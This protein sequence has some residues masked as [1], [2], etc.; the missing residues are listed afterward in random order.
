MEHWYLVHTKPSRERQV[1]VQLHQRGF[2][3]YLPLIW[4]SPVNPRASRERPFFPRHLF[5]KLDLQTVG[6]DMIR[7]LPDVNGLI[8]FN[9]E[10]ASLSDA[11]VAE[12]QECLTRVRA[13]GTMG[14]DGARYSDFVPANKGPFEAYEGMLNAQ[15]PGVD[16]A[17]ILLACVQQ[18]FWSQNSRALPAAGVSDDSAALTPSG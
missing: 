4:V 9:G 2:A 16:R 3:V 1:A 10:P 13:V 8:E 15:L 12:L 11:F 17:R 14:F 5:A 6:A 18:E 7:W